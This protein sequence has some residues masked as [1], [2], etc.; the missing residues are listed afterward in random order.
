M[1]NIQYPISNITEASDH[2]IDA[3]KND[4]KDELPFS[5]NNN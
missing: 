2:I 5:A 1:S 3:T 4:K